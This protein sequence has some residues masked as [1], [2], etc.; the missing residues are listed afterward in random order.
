M[1]RILSCLLAGVLLLSALTCLAGCGG[2]PKKNSYTRVVVSIDGQVEIM[3]DGGGLVA[4]VTPLDE[5]AARLVYEDLVDTEP[6]WAV[7]RIVTIATEL[8]V[9][10]RGVGFS[11]DNTVN[12]SVDGEGR[13]A[14][15]LWQKL[16]KRAARAMQVERTA[17]SVGDLS[18][19]STADLRRLVAEVTP[20][21]ATEVEDMEKQEL[22]AHL[23]AA[24]RR[25]ALLSFTS[26]E[27][28]TVFAAMLETALALARYEALAEVLRQKG[29]SEYETYAAALAEYKTACNTLESARFRVLAQ[30]DSDYRTLVAAVNDV[31]ARILLER[32]SAERM[33]VGTEEYQ[34]LTARIEKLQ[35]D[36]TT[37]EDAMREKKQSV[38]LGIHLLAKT[39]S[40][41]AGELDAIL[42]SLKGDVADAVEAAAIPSD[43]KVMA[44]ATAVFSE[45]YRT[46]IA[47][48]AAYYEAERIRLRGEK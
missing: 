40:K 30:S 48:M 38:S 20:L 14:D 45:A 19:T 43:E 25:A 26:P 10:T 37:A 1:K 4:S 33:V 36:Y 31:T 46:D 2:S 5:N 27:Q 21:S 42:A 15:K 39:Q 34:A 29:A 16:T 41:K 23:T 9:L 44:D 13:Y 12:I 11:G 3:I 47:A 32:T 35:E 6:E 8:G 24:R 17:G 22:F 28:S 18:V 7:D